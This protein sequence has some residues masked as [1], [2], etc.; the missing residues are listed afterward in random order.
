MWHV[1]NTLRFFSSTNAWVAAIAAGGILEGK[2]IL[3]AF[4]E[5]DPPIDVQLDVADATAVNTHGRFPANAAAQVFFDAVAVGDLINVVIADTPSADVF[6]DTSAAIEAGAPTV[7]ADAETVAAPIVRDTAAEVEAGAPSVTAAAEKVDI[8]TPFHDTAAEVTAGAPGVEAIAEALE[9]GIN[10]TGIVGVDAPAPDVQA[11]VDKVEAVTHDTE[12]EVTAAAPTV[13]ADAD[14]VD[15]AAPHDVEVEVDAGAAEFDA[16]AETVETAVVEREAGL[17]AGAP[18]VAVSA[19]KLAIPERAVAVDAGAPSVEARA[20]VEQAGSFDVSADITAGAP[21]IEPTPVKTGLYVYR[22]TPL[23][24]PFSIEGGA[25]GSVNRKNI[26]EMSQG[27]AMPNL[28]AFNLEAW[29]RTPETWTKGNVFSVNLAR[30]IETNIDDL[31]LDYNLFI[32][33]RRVARA[34]GA[35]DVVIWPY[36]SGPGRWVLGQRR[37]K[38]VYPRAQ[39]SVRVGPDGEDYD[40][41]EVLIWNIHNLLSASWTGQIPRAI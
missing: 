30:H 37:Q 22:I 1:S 25:L 15:V 38:Y 5:T 36:A 28:W 29:V 41:A 13:T 35:G 39:I 16:R 9:F 12:A 31:R 11:D 3:L 17:S 18:S 33:G 27:R 21:G 32:H 20:E 14:K 40:R 8:E 24:S 7:E 23:Q 26:A 4:D 10:E 19:G 2:S 6:V 34:L